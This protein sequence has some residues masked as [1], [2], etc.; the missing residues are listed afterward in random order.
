MKLRSERAGLDQPTFAIND[1]T[2]ADSGQKVT[3]E[4]VQRLTDEELAKLGGA[5]L[6]DARALFLEVAVADEFVEFLTLPAYERMP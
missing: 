4:L 5:G 2:L 1:V 3:R 6:E